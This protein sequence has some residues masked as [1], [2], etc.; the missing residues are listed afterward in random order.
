MA[1]LFSAL[2]LRRAGWRVDVYERVGAEL[3]GRGAGIVTYP[4]L[5]R[6]VA[7]A[8]VRCEP[9]ELGVEVSGRV[10]IDSAGIVRGELALPQVLTSWGRLYAVLRSALP[11]ERYHP[12]KSLEVVEQD[13]DGV[14]ARFSDGSEER[15]DL[16]V[17]ADGIHSTVRAQFLPKVKPRYAGYVAWRGIINEQELSEKVRETLC[18]RFAF[19]LPAGEQMLGYPVSGA[20][21]E[22]NRFYNFVWYRP[23]D[24]RGELKRLLTDVDGI[25]YDL[26][27]PPNR[28]HPEQIAAMRADAVRLLAPQFAEVVARTER[29]FIQPIFDLETPRMT[30][31]RVAFVGD[32]AF[33]ARPHVGMGVTKAAGDAATLADQ[34]AAAPFKPIEALALFEAT[35]LPFGTAVIRRA[36][37]LGAYLQAQIRTPAERILAERHRRPEAVMAETAVGEGVQV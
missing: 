28:I 23:A 9:K 10:V 16:L 3:A 7:T 4:D 1:G 26:S 32:A 37:A 29:P 35:R 21:D 5:W 13:A 18:D 12:G 15:A 11:E 36:R 14:T 24:E 17:A 2:F 19:C 22:R 20:A 25:R 30:V 33:V 27:I 31:G 8:G 34:L 6:M